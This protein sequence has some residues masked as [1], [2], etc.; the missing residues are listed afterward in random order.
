MLAAANRN[1]RRV[2]NGLETEFTLV[3]PA[4]TD[5]ERRDID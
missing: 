3:T 4:V 1:L 2:M 5:G